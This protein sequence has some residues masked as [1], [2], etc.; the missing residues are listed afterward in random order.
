MDNNSKMLH[1]VDRMNILHW[2]VIFIY[3][4]VKVNSSEESKDKD[5]NP[6]QNEIALPMVPLP[7]SDSNQK[8]SY[9]QN[10]DWT[11]VTRKKK[12]K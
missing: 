4:S 12:P 9:G 11:T 3:Q 1:L 6:M 5:N 10:G 8:P 7:P 2:I